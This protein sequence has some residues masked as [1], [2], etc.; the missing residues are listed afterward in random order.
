MKAK[1]SLTEIVRV[2]P[3]SSP[4]K[5]NIILKPTIGEFEEPI[6]KFKFITDTGYESHFREIS[7]LY[8]RDGKRDGETMIQLSLG[9]G[10]R[11]ETY[12]LFTRDQNAI[13]LAKNYQKY[14][15]LEDKL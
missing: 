14:T 7:Q 13:N 2:R 8:F 3:R 5:G 11:K 1:E 9:K 6:Y 4:L 15:S 12:A 10:E